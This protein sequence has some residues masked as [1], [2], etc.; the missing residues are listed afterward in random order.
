MGN[1]SLLWV[2]GLSLR[3]KWYNY[4]IFL[5]YP[6]LIFSSCSSTVPSKSAKELFGELDG[7]Q[8]EDL[9]EVYK[10]DFD[11]HGYNPYSVLY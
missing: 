9:V 6:S 4:Q 8:L 3:A 7:G 10:E 2:G 1:F 5:V 11:I